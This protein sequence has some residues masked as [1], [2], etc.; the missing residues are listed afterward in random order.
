MDTRPTKKAATNK[1]AIAGAN[2]QF[3]FHHGVRRFL[4]SGAIFCQV[5]SNFRK[6]PSRFRHGNLPASI[7]QPGKVVLFGAAL[8]AEPQVRCGVVSSP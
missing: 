4:N 2:I 5:R 6:R 1:V 7:E 8:W 3:C